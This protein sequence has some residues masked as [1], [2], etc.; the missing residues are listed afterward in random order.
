MNQDSSVLAAHNNLMRALAFAMNHEVSDEPSDSIGRIE[1]GDDS[2]DQPWTRSKSTLTESIAR[3]K[4]L[5]QYRQRE[6]SPGIEPW[7]RPLDIDSGSD[8]E[9]QL[10]S[11]EEGVP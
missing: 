5:I 7:Y 3:T 4:G 6:W 10:S 8:E 9:V 1:H 2:T 11:Q